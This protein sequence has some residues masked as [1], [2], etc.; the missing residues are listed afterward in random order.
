MMIGFA[1]LLLKKDNEKQKLKYFDS[2]QLLSV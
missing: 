2:V 1:D